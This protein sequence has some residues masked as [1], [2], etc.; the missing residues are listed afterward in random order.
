MVFEGDASTCPSS[1]FLFFP[2]SPGI[3]LLYPYSHALSKAYKRKTGEAPCAPRSEQ[4]VQVGKSRGA[5]SFATHPGAV[6]LSDHCKTTG[7]EACT[8]LAG[9]GQLGVSPFT[10]NTA[11]AQRCQRGKTST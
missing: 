11:F 3:G 10:M 5:T 6:R 9:T 1:C 7:R 8:V 2:D 4:L